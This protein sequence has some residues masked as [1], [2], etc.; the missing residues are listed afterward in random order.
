MKALLQ[1]KFYAL[2]I[3]PT[4]LLSYNEVDHGLIKTTKEKNISKTYSVDNNA[5][6]KV[7]NSYGNV[8]IIT[9]DQN[10]IS[11]DITIKVTGSNEEKVMKRLDAIDVDFSASRSMVSAETK[12]GNRNRNSWWNWGSNNEKIEV[13]Y[14]VKIPKS[15]NINISN[16]YGS[17]NVD[18]LYGK[19]VLNCDYGKISTKELMADN[20]ELNFDYSNGSYFEYIKSGKIN[21]DYSDYTVAKVKDLVINAD[22]TKSKIEVAENIEYS[23]DYG[24]LTA[25]NINNL[26]GNGDYLTLRLGNVYKNVAIKADYGS[27]KID[28]MA[29]GSGNIDIETDYT[30][31][32]I[33]LSQDYNFKFDINLQ[34]GGLRHPDGFEFVKKRVESFEKYY[35]GYF[36]NANSNNFVRIKSDYGSLNFKEQ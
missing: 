10:T 25:E 15:N 18:Q 2:L 21:A 27:I 23:C 19:A 35:S 4:A 1:F 31:I 3:V 5:T 7:D 36:R 16:D 32:T 26:T 24:S 8:D 20:N 33:G 22:Y 14:V 28:K 13:N 30:G 11:F 9:W 17:I 6:L 12:F 34:Y 29:S